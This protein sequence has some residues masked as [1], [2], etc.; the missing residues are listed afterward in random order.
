ML[1]TGESEAEYFMELTRA[2]TLKIKIY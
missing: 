2:G 1:F